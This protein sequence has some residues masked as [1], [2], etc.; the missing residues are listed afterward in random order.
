MTVA[1]AGIPTQVAALM[2]DRTLERMFH[3]ALYP[4]LLFRAEARPELWQANLGERMVFTR[5]GLMAVDTSPRIPGKDPVPKSYATEQWVAEASQ[6][7][8]TIDTHLPT[9]YVTMAPT[10]LSDTQSLGL[11]AGQTMNRLA[12][13]RMFS[14]YLGG[15][16][17]NRV[18]G[19]IGSVQLSVDTL[20]GFGERLVNGVLAPVSGSNPLPVTFTA[21]GEPANTVVG[22]TPDNPSVPLGPGVLILSAPLTTAV[23][24]RSAVLA[25]TR[26][27]RT[28]V[29]GGLTVDALTASNLLTLNDIIAAISR[30][31]TQNVPPHADGKYHVHLTP[32]GEAQL[33][34][35]NHW[36]RLHQSLPDSS[37]YRDL[38][39]GTCV[40]ANFYRNTELPDL[41]NVS[42][43][44]ALPGTVGGSLLAPEIGGEI[45]NDIGLGINRTLITGG[46]VLYEKYLDE[47]KFITEAGVQGKI[48]E[49]SIING[50]VAVMVSR[51]RYILRSPQDRLQQQVAQTWS[52]SGDFPVPS[53]LLVGDGARFKRAVVIESAG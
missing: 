48:G 53:D 12:R 20:N 51:V 30:L 1:L 27:R 16:A 32:V 11:N 3:D 40:G 28:R 36:Q 29:G 46:G 50:G 44:T 35:D 47:S 41:T 18:L 9:S 4:A 42:A 8:D 25:S 26:S 45:T 24:V 43:T 38:A 49:F 39:I 10:F 2:Q 34:A 31:R 17:M 33:F 15:E 52:W 5:R 14:A 7:H 6:I 22:V 37:A 13:N 21:A 19:V 23:P